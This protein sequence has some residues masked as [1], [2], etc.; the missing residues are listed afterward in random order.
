[1][2]VYTWKKRCELIQIFYLRSTQVTKVLF[3]DM[4]PKGDNNLHN[5]PS[6]PRQRK[7]PQVK[8]KI[9]YS[10]IWVFDTEGIMHNQFVPTCQTI[11]A[12]CYRDILQWK[13]EDMRKCPLRPRNDLV[14]HHSNA[15][16]HTAFII[17]H[18]FAKNMVPYSAYS[19]YLATRD[20]FLFPKMK[21]KLKRRK[22]DTIEKIYAELQMVL[23]TLTK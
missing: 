17:Q 6:L 14:L 5:G 8:S 12:D 18:N 4:I 22:S 3:M 20:C 9:K 23:N 2:S 21:I 7:A 1:M 10:L 19:P 11:K 15:N 16:S 13:M